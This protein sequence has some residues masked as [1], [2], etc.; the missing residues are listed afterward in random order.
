MSESKRNAVERL[1]AFIDAY[2]E[3]L[4]Q[5]S[6]EELL[7]APQAQA[8]ERSRFAK[9]VQAAKLEAGKRRLKAA[10]RTLNQRSTEP[11]DEP[12][13]VA[14]ARRFIA[15]AVN[16]P[17]FTLAARDLKEMSDED[18]ERIYRQLKDLGI[19]PNEKKP[20]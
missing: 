7:G 9:I 1:Q 17:R 3:S 16:D 15:D 2:L 6:E 10:R 14:E 19:S 5:Q 20:G 18:V 8:A 13:D 4:Q 11:G 12:I